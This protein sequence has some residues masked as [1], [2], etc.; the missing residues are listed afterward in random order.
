[1]MDERQTCTAY[2]DYENLVES[3]SRYHS[4]DIVTLLNQVLERARQQFRIQRI[5]IFGNWTLYPMPTQIDTRG[6]VRRACID[7]GI[8]ASLEIEESIIQGLSSKESSE[9]YLLISGQARYL[10]A[11]KHLHQAHKRSILWTLVPL[12]EQEQT[13]STAHET[14]SLPSTLARYKWSRHLLLQAF[15]L[16]T[17]QASTQVSN[18]LT[19]PSLREVLQQ[20]SALEAQADSLLSLALRERILLLQEAPDLLQEPQVILNKRHELTQQALQI[21]E[22]ILNTVCVLQEKRGWVAFSTLDKALS[23]HRL[24]AGNQNFR[25][26]WI[27]LLIESGS[28]LSTRRASPSNQFMTTTVCLNPVNEQAIKEHKREYNLTTLICVADIYEQRRRKVW[29]SVGQLRRCLTAHMTYTEAHATLKQALEQQVLQSET[30]PSK[31][32]PD[33]NITVVWENHQHPLVQEKLTRRDRLLLTSYALLT[34]RDFRV[35]ESLLLEEFS[36]AEHLSEDE[37]RYWLRLLVQERIV[38]MTPL[39]AQVSTG[40]HILSLDQDDPLVHQLL[41]H[42]EQGMSEVKE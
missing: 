37:A 39:E 35:S 18:G 2:V 1:M 22:R 21:Q 8:D 13:W 32:N 24:L 33:H 40:E 7:P 31:R 12:S 3:L 11:L 20:S 19:L 38:W 17:A 10:E 41:E 28:L 30:R 34:Q 4:L 9:V 29:I 16:E 15:I 25:H 23:T 27:E 5:L 42:V 26:N 6:V 14:L 36:A